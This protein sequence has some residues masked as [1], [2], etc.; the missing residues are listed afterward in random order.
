MD[1]YRRTMRESGFDADAE[2]AAR[3]QIQHSI[4]CGSPDTVSEAVATLK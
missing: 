2:L 3:N 4:L 1:L